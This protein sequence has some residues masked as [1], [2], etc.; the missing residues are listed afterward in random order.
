MFWPQSQLDQARHKYK[1]HKTSVVRY[2][3]F[4]KKKKKL[5]NNLN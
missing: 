3:S 4:E 2:H 5:K 1:I